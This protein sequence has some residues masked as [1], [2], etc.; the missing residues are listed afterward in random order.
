[1]EITRKSTATINK[2]FAAMVAIFPIALKPEHI[3]VNEDGT[4]TDTVVELGIANDNYVQVKSGLELNDKVQIT[5]ELTESTKKSSDSNNN[6]FGGLGSFSG[7]N[8]R[9]S[10]DFPTG[11]MPNFDSSSFKGSGSGRPS[12]RN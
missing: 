7:G 10:G 3:K 5:T 11:N 4:I 12:S 1:M 9:P 6:G 2:S 8:N